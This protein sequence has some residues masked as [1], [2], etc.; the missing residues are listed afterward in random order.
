MVPDTGSVFVNGRKMFKT[1]D[2]FFQKN[3]QTIL[4][5]YKYYKKTCYFN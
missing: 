5:V 4:I 2:S 1:N 3:E